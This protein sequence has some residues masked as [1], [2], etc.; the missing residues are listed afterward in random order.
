MR[1]PQAPRPCSNSP[2]AKNVLG[3]ELQPCSQEPLTGFYRDGCCNTGAEDAGVHVVC[4]RVTAEFLEFSKQAGNDLSTPQLGFAGLQPGDQWCLCADRWQ[5]AL[6]AG[7]APDVASRPPT[8]EP[9]NGSTWRTFAATRWPDRLDAHGVMCTARPPGNVVTCRRHLAP[10]LTRP[11]RVDRPG[12]PRAPGTARTRPTAFGF[13]RDRTVVAALVVLA[14]LLRVPNLGRAYWIDEGI[15]VGIASHPLRQI[16]GLLRQDGSPPLFYVVLHFW[17]QAFGNSPVNT[18]LLLAPGVPRR[19]AG[20]ILG[21]VR[22]L[23][24]A[25]RSGRGRA[26]GHQS[27]PGLVLDRDAHVPHRGGARHGRARPGRPGHAQPG[28][29][30]HGRCRSRLRG[31]ALHPQLGHLPPRRHGGRCGSGRLGAV[32]TGSWRWA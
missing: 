28:L 8:C 19:R 26:D 13:G 6:E 22:A 25:G 14:F 27:L 31:A 7:M 20:G 5:E 12:G 17:M 3:S 9:S 21:R 23:R 16:P 18:H 30:G 4:S 24:P 29:A 10:R 1:G 11:W 15:S 32:T 2:M